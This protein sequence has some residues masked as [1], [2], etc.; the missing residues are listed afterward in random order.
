MLGFKLQDGNTTK[1]Y[2]GNTTASITWITPFEA[3]KSAATTVAEFPFSSVNV[4]LPCLIFATSL[5]PLTVVSVKAPPFALI[6]LI[7]AAAS[8]VPATTW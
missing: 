6:A 3:V 1:N 2:F 8:N 7:T 5:F 4:T